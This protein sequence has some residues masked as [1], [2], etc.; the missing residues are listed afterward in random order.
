MNK[1]TTTSEA[2]VKLVLQH[3]YNELARRVLAAVSKNERFFFRNVA[4]TDLCDLMPDYSFMELREACERLVSAELLIYAAPGYRLFDSGDIAGYYI[5]AH[6]HHSSVL[7][8][9]GTISIP[10]SSTP[11]SSKP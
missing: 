8:T 7:E 4:I 5:H 11:K 10:F 1:S 6:H 2:R 9:I 3:I